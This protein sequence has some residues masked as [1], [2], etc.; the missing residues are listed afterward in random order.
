MKRTRFAPNAILVLIF[1]LSVGATTVQLFGQAGTWVAK[2]PMPTPRLAAAA[3]SVNGIVYV[4]GGDVSWFG[5]GFTGVNEAYNPATDTWTTMAPMP[6]ARAAYAAAVVNG[7]IYIVGGS[8]GCFPPSRV[9]EAYDPAPTHG[10]PRPNFLTL[11][12]GWESQTPPSG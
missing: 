7:I 2:A 12:L 6:T 3:A 1:T 11:V 4:I 10:V 9:V 5:C 8:E